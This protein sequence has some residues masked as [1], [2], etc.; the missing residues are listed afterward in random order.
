VRFDFIR[1]DAIIVPGLVDSHAHL[2]QYGWA[3]TLDLS[4]SQSIEEVVR[5]VQEYILARR[6]VEA[7][8]TAWI[9]GV[10]WDQ[11]LW[12]DDVFPTFVSFIQQR[13][14]AHLLTHDPT[15]LI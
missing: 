14:T 15:R 7:D 6:D 2:L 4:D 8:T 1:H 5:R 3:K 10:G 11:S 12:K 9:E 13:F